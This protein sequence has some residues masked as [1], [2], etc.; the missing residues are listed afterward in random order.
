M[1][2]IWEDGNY[3]PLDT[4][5]ITV[6]GTFSLYEENNEMYCTLANARLVD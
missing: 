1:I 4:E 5:E 3:P 6:E 2:D